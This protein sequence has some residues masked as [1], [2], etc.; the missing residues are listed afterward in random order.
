MERRMLS[1]KRVNIGIVGLGYWGPNLVRNFSEVNN[2]YVAMACDSDEGRLK[3]I[4]R[5]YP[6]VEVTTRYDDLVSSK[7]VDAIA[8]A[9]PVVSHYELAKNALEK[10]KHVLVEKPL[11]ANVKEADD[12]M[13]IAQGQERILMVDHT[14]LYTGSVR[15]TKELISRGEIGELYY[16]DSVRINLGLFRPDVNVIWDL[17]PHDISIAQYLIKEEPVSVSVLGRDFNNNKI[18]CIAY[19]TLRYKSGI[20]AHIHVSWLSPV[21]IRRIIIGGSK[22]MI[23]YDDVEPTEKIKVYDSGIKFDY[24]KE[25]PLQ[26]TYRLGDINLPRLDQREALLVEAEH[27]IDCILNGKRP[28]TDAAFGL[29]IVKILEASDISLKEGGREIK[30]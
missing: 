3:P 26:P 14:F 20:I 25:N 7:E 11:C 5:R 23:I 28:L 1:G 13:K 22:K 27:F 6:Y 17:A 19:M 21:K 10:G 15:K 18:A 4:K 24:D 16:F 9:T 2:C 12:L 8:I 30:L 29:A